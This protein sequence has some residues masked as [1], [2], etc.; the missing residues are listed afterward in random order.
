[1]PPQI[2]DISNNIGYLLLAIFL[3]LLIITAKAMSYKHFEF[4]DWLY[5]QEINI[6]TLLIVP[7]LVVVGRFCLNFSGNGL[8]WFILPIMG[9]AIYLIIMFITCMLISEDRTMPI[10]FDV[11]PV[12]SQIFYIIIAGIAV[13]CEIFV[14]NY[15][16]NTH[17]V[18]AAIEYLFYNL[19]I[20]GSVSLTVMLLK[21]LK[22]SFKREIIQ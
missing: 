21:T 2:I 11:E 13:L 15:V 1:L 22:S 6:W 8:G 14:A 10:G 17:N 9:I 18:S 12:C 5:L 19:G 4:I 3:S 20:I 7:L 16:F